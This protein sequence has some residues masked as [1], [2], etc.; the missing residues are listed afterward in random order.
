MFVSSGRAL[1]TTWKITPT[2][3]N[4]L[5]HSV[6]SGPGGTTSPPGP[7]FLGKRKAPGV[8]EG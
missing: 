2:L 8:T 3:R 6:S 1:S 5:L 4:H 7:L